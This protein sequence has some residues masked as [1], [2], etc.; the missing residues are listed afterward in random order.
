[1]P[2]WNA[3]PFLEQSLGSICAQT[4][5]SFELIVVDDG[6][7][8]ETP[9]I[10]AEWAGRDGRIRVVRQE[11][12][13]LV[14]APQR[15]LEEAGGELVARIDAD[16]IAHPRRLEWQL[17]LMEA[18]PEVAMLGGLVRFFP[19]AKMRAG[20]RRY[21]RW[22]NSIQTHDE[23]LRD[24]FVEHPLAHPSVMMRADAVRRA[25]GYSEAGWAE[26]YDLCF[27]MLADGARFEKAP[28]V[29]LWWRDR[30]DRAT[31]TQTRYAS[32]E[33]RRCKVHYLK[34][35]HLGERTRVQIWGAGKEGRALGKHVKRA[36]LEIAR[37]L[38]VA[39]TKIGRELLGAPIEDRERLKKDEYLLVAVGAES[40]RRLIREELSA[41]GWAEPEH[42]RTM[43]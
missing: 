43:A 27:R 28:R 22:L 42:Y 37:Y 12:A 32:T 10:L 16:D 11:H 34:R 1:M 19:R 24:F 31:R 41:L 5:R 39:P 3:A 9:R 40:A 35:L 21:E 23:I 7:T 13:G 2:C 33:F 17:E 14:A 29:V 30:P 36:G 18:R 25:G 15:A 20:M 26:D 4:L 6:S 8:D 38:D